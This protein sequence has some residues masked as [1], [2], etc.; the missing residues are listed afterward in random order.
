MDRLVLEHG[1]S[2]VGFEFSATDFT[3]PERNQF[4]YRMV[5]FDDDWVD[6]L[7]DRQA[8][9]TNLDAGDYRFEVMG[10][11]N[12]GVWNP[13]ARALNIRINPPLWQTWWAYSLYVAAF[14]L[15]LFLLLQNNTRRQRF[16][17]EKRYSE[18]L[19]LY[20]ES[21]EQATDCILIADGSGRSCSRIMRFADYSGWLLMW[22]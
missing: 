21:L 9:Y 8:T 13:E 20:V 11:N 5:G 6:A 3:Q 1:D 7:G 16:A 19:Q 15:A 14:C 18:R 4:R 22:L 12:D 17:A 10:S 2:V